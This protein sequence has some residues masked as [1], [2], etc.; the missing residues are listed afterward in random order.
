MEP[1]TNKPARLFGLYVFCFAIVVVLVFFYVW[2]Y[3]QVTEL[4]YKLEKANKELAGIEAYNRELR[5]KV[6][7]ADSLARVEK[8]AARLGLSSP[9][10][11]QMVVLEDPPI[12]RKS[13]NAE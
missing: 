10:K 8:E 3:T 6:M 1:Q 13:V 9:D 4:R 5:L 11:G 12:I 2:E 7:N